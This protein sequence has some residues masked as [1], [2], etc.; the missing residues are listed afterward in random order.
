MAGVTDVL[1]EVPAALQPAV[2]QLQTDLDTGL[3][4]AS[5]V[6]ADIDPAD[7][8]AIV[9]DARAVEAAAAPLMYGAD[10][11]LASP[12]A[13][14]AI[15]AAAIANLVIQPTPTR[16]QF[17]AINPN[18]YALAA[19]YLNDVTRWED[20][21]DASGIYPPDPQPIGQ[22]LIVIPSS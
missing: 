12:A 20:I 21:A 5:G 15:R 13:D 3:Q 18:L 2:T 19:Q 6:I 16:Q 7:S 9:A 17:R 11:T 10:C 8:A 14:M 4:D 22:F 1:F